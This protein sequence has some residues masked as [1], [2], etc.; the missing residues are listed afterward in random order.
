[1]VNYF[2]L[3]VKHFEYKPGWEPLKYVTSCKY[4]KLATLRWA[5]KQNA[6]YAGYCCID[7]IKNEIC[8]YTSHRE[9]S[10]MEQLLLLHHIGLEI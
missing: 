9:C 8:N 3:K 1:M 10:C 7:E 5:T 6:T 4:L 2:L